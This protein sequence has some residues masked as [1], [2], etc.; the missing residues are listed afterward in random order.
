MQ[1]AY[2]E[3]EMLRGEVSQTKC[4]RPPVS[5]SHRASLHFDSQPLPLHV[6]LDDATLGIQ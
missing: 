1:Q 6:L 2:R 4:L 5:S 3:V